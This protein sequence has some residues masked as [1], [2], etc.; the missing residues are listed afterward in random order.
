MADTTRA[1]DWRD[2]FRGESKHLDYKAAASWDECRA[3]LLKHIIAMSN[4]RDGGRI[5]VGVKENGESGVHEPEGLTDPQLNSF[6]TTKIAQYVNGYVQPGVGVRVAKHEMNGV[7]V[8]VLEVA[9]FQQ[10]PNICTQQAPDQREFKPGDVVIRTDAAQSQVIRTAEEMREL[11]RLAI[12]KTTETLLRDVKRIVEG[13][14]AV[15]A[16]ED[17][18]AKLL[19]TWEESR[20]AFADRVQSERKEGGVV[21]TFWCVMRPI[22]AQEAL[23]HSDLR[24]LMTRAAVNRGGYNFPTSQYDR[25]FN[26]DGFVEGIEGVEGYEHEWRA[27]AEGPITYVEALRETRFD[28]TRMNLERQRYLHFARAC[29]KVGLTFMLAQRILEGRDYSGDICFNFG[30]TDT[31]GRKLL[32]DAPEIWRPDW[33]E[34]REKEIRESVTLTAVDIKAGWEAF[35]ANLLGRVFALFQADRSQAAIESNLRKLQTG[36]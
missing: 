14:V 29:D 20:R 13:Q 36:H 26:R 7:R 23:G 33:Y 6:D 1:D 18:H 12:G 11:L 25:V 16:P 17:R 27:Y 21:A 10:F 2:L 5:V 9:E 15:E 8:V 4:V 34:C 35:A 3:S 30:W 31:E 22:D 28:F 32:F 19:A 24:A